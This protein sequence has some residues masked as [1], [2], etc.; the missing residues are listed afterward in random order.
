MDR[1]ID[2]RDPII[3]P[4]KSFSFPDPIRNKPRVTAVPGK[5]SLA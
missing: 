2:V 3:M 4:I 5:T 1:A